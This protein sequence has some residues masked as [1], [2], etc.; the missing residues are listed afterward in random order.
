MFF[1][2]SY[3]RESLIW[4]LAFVL[5]LEAAKW[6]A[7]RI[8]AGAPLR[9]FVMLPVLLAMCAGLWVELRQV[10]RMDELQRMKYLVATL[11]GSMLAVLFCAVATLGEALHLWARVAPIYAIVALAAGFVV[12]LIAAQRHYG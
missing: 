6:G 10:A 4:I 12:G 1:S 5:A 3:L 2:K 9:V 11:A 8:D 7:A